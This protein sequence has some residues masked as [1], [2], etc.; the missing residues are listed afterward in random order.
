MPWKLLVRVGPRVERQRFDSLEQALDA[1][2]RRAGE[3]ARATSKKPR[4]TRLKRYDPVQQVAA[5]IELAGPQRLLPSRHAGID[6]RGD[7]SMEA[8]LGRIRRQ[9]VELR[10]GETASQALRRVSETGLFE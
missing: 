6:V 9:P 7:G 8:F 10:H 1:A 2:E 4:E 5:R 3:L